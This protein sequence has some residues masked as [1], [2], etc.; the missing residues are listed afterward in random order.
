MDPIAP[1]TASPVHGSPQVTAASSSTS[2]PPTSH[3]FVSTNENDT[4]TQSVTSGAGPSTGAIPPLHATLPSAETQRHIDEARRAVV[5]SIGNLVDSEL[6]SRASILHE[7]ATALD[8]QEK[9]IV[10]ETAGLRR[11]REKLAQEADMAARKL[12]EVGN[13]QNWAEVLE[14]QFMVLEETARLVEEGSE[15]GSDTAS[16]CSCSDC[17][18]MDDD[19]QHDD[20]QDAYSETGDDVIAG[21]ALGE[22]SNTASGINSVI[23]LSDPFIILEAC[24][25]FWNARCALTT[26]QGG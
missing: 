25:T 24:C 2:S 10:A 7:N 1:D 18:K 19:Q 22:S 16:S 3:T 11:E 8:K 20:A 9:E 23:V 17:G 13:V 4:A 21:S 14:R 5:A 12:K 6:Q 26:G 15:S